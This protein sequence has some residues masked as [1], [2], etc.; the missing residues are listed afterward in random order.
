MK[1]STEYLFL[2][3][4]EIKATQELLG[5]YRT[6]LKWTYVPR[7]L[8]GFLLVKIGLRKA[9]EPALI[10]KLK[11]EKSEKEEKE[12][13]AKISQLKPVISEFNDLPPPI[14]QVVTPDFNSQVPHEGSTIPSA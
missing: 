3:D 13:K 12:A 4:V 7:V 8:I 10:N 5:V 9:P 14:I 6:A 1:D 11:A 2:Q